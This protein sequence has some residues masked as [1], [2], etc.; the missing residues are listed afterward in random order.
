MKK[1]LIAIGCFVFLWTSNGFSEQLK[2]RAWEIGTEISHIQYKEPSVMTEKGL[3]YGVCGSYVYSAKYILKVDGR[4]SSGQ[5]DYKNSGTINNID[6]YILE[7]RGVMGRDFPLSGEKSIMPYIGLGYRYLNDDTSGMTSSTGAKGYERESNYYYTPIG[8][9][10]NVPLK[11]GWLTSTMLEFDYFWKGVQKSHLSDAIVG[12]SDLENDQ[13]KGYGIRSSIK[14]K[15]EK[16][17]VNY[18]I[19]PFIR[20]WNIKKSED[21][22]ITYAGVIVGYGY[23]PKNNSMEVGMKFAVEF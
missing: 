23:E 9:V 10:I 20:Y 14:F 2:K 7:F 21:A 5:V 13:N 17:K 22:N 11:S 6:D 4:F 15:K 3:M 18:V 16:E 19:E 1:I 12:V 8:A